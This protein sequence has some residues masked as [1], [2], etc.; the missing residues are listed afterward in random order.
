VLLLLEMLKIKWMAALVCLVISGDIAVK[1][2]LQGLLMGCLA[3]GLGCAT[4]P[5]QTPEEVVGSR[6]LEQAR[7]LMAADYAMAMS[8]MTPTYQSSP[9]S[10]NYQRAR[11]GSGSWQKVDLK[12]VRCDADYNACDVR[13]LITAFRPPAVTFP[14]QIPLDDKWIEVDGQWYQYD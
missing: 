8:Y 13:L 4:S 11:A 7:A 9:R 3:S 10:D 14:I 1:Y 12:W 5:T 6:A 2:L